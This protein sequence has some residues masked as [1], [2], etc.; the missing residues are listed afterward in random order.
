MH[1][2]MEKLLDKL[3]QSQNPEHEREVVKNV[4]GVG[5]VGAHSLS[6]SL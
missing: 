6:L 3:E 1:S 5:F 2:I 4:A